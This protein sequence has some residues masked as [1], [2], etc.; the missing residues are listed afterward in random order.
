MA[1][2]VIKVVRI[3]KMETKMVGDKPTLV[4]R[5]TIEREQNLENYDI[6]YTA[7]D[8]R[9]MTAREW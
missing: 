7:E 3:M 6:N 5:F 2:Q 1:A 8:K 9:Y 4:P